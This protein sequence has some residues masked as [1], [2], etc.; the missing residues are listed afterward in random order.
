MSTGLRILISLGLQF[1]LPSQIDSDNDKI[2]LGTKLRIKNYN[3]MGV[4]GDVE[5]EI[6][7]KHVCGTK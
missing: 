4:G 3:M 7:S 2:V 5:K 1:K 6:A